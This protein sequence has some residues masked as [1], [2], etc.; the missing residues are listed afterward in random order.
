MDHEEGHHHYSPRDKGPN[1]PLIFGSL[2]ALLVVAVLLFFFMSAQQ[3]KRDED[4]RKKAEA[5]AAMKAAAAANAPPP[6][7]EQPLAEP[8]PEP[9]E[10]PKPVDVEDA[11]PELR[12]GD[13]RAL[14]IPEGKTRY[15]VSKAEMKTYEYPD[16]VTAE[17]K[18]EIEKHVE[19]LLMSG[20][21]QRD[22]EKYFKKLDGFPKP[23]EELKAV[24]R[25]ISEFPA[26]IEEFGLTGPEAMSRLRV[27]DKTLRAIDGMQE[28]DFRDIDGINIASDDRMAMRVIKRWNWWW[29]LH[30]WQLRRQPWDPREDMLDELEGEGIGDD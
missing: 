12:E 15:M 30:K 24:G 26:V 11:R 7:E 18:A 19:M 16:H 8:E 17:E 20:R 13:L 21:D 27:I 1:M 5:E 25:L 4:E 3:K 10:K 23:G 14:P 28:R 9:V 22:A 29:D 2:G 6:I